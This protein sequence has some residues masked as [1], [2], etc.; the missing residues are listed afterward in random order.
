MCGCNKNKRITRTIVPR[1]VGSNQSNNSTPATV[2][3]MTKEQ[4]DVERKRRMQSIL[5]KKKFQ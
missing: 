1:N 5:N 3:G 2:T 4:R